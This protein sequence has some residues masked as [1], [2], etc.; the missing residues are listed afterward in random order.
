MTFILLILLGFAASAYGTI[1]GAGGGFLFV[2]ALLTFYEIS[3]EAAAATGLAIVF[4][5][6]A[7]GM[8][9]LLKQRRILIR[10][11]LFLSLGAI[12]GTFLGKW[13]VTFSPDGI[14][15]AL[16]AC[17]LIGLG[18][19]LTLKKQKPAKSEAETA[20]TAENVM[21]SEETKEENEDKS[22]EF[23]KLLLTGALLG[24]ISS[25]FGIGGGW[26][27]VPILVYGY[28]LSIK[29]ATATSMFSLAIYSLVGLIPS[30]ID[31]SVDWA[32]VG[33]SGIG[34][35]LGAQAGAMLSKKMKATT[36]VRLLA[37]V[38]IIMGINMFF[39]I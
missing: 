4:I 22:V 39:Q 30:V 33:M 38:V 25:F 35:L 20:A 6:A 31:Q 36:I 9:L 16:F 1:I 34:V 7:A 24:V 27:L 19:F 21:S 23:W 29:A 26:L 15:Y 18:L 11:G 37:A 17:L 28:S 10:T 2:P 12:P 13:L 32:V 3:P 14:F 5:N 8:P